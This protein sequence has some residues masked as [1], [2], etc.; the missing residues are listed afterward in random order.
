MPFILLGTDLVHDPSIEDGYAR[1]LRSAGF[2][3][4]IV[5]PMEHSASYFLARK[6]FIYDDA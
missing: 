3:V 6:S 1:I 5:R 2:S 4:E